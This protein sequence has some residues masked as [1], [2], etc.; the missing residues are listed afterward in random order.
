M[1]KQHQQLQ[2]QMQQ[3]QAIM[4]KSRNMSCYGVLGSDSSPE[5][6]SFC[7]KKLNVEFQFN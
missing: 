4:M 2:F 7:M 1:G 5:M 6:E 3:Q